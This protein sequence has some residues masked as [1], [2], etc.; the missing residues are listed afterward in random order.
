MPEL[1]LRRNGE[2]HRSG[3]VLPCE[4]VRND[5]IWARIT[6]TFTAT[7]C[8]G[9]QTQAVQEIYLLRPAIPENQQPDELVL[10]SDACSADVDSM[11]AELKK[12]YYLHDDPYACDADAQ[13]A[14][15][16]E[17]GS[18]K[19]KRLECGYSFD[20]TVVNWRLT[21]YAPVAWV[22]VLVHYFDW[23][24]GKPVVIDT[25]LLKWYDAKG[26]SIALPEKPV[27]ISTG[28]MD[29]TAAFGIDLA[30]LKDFFGVEVTDNCEGG[31]TVD[32]ELWSCVDSLLYGIP[33]EGKKW[34]KAAYQTMQTNGR[35]MALGVPVGAHKLRITAFD[36]CYNQSAKE[37]YF[38]VQDKIAPVV[39][40]DDRLN[41]TLTNSQGYPAAGTGVLA[42]RRYWPARS[43][44]APRTTAAWTG[45]RVRRQYNPACLADFLARG[46]DS[47]NDGDIDAQDG[48]D[49]NQDGDLDD[50]MEKFE[51]SKGDPTILM[52][53]ALDYAEFFCCDL[54]AEGV[55]VEL[56][57]Q[58]RYMEMSNCDGGTLRSGGNL[59]FLLDDGEPG[60]QE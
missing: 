40:C 53:P 46:Y 25:I 21:K 5:Q 48:I 2:S 54:G 43:A 50:L 28:P 58:D 49:W 9:N 15:F 47:D 4:T 37:V 10:R 3:D 36:Q 13:Y 45:S 60:R 55:M 44:K 20:V 41:V 52:T 7:D 6:R 57:A 23:C 31:V 27:V 39:K 56:W 42:M 14:Y 33:V 17:A 38:E 32:V 11:I 8:Y 1:P 59:K 30:S 22:G 19:T 35:R 29:C 18:G 16:P 26:P 24:T 12:N 51:Y 34:R